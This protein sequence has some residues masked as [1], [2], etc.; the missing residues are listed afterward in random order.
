MEHSL[1]FLLIFP[2]LKSERAQ[3]KK[4]N[5]TKNTPFH[6]RSE[7]EPL[8]LQQSIWRGFENR[9]SN[10]GNLPGFSAFFDFWF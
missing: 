6:A 5:K 3:S 1:F 2:R 8:G 10:F 9:V 7:N 4:I